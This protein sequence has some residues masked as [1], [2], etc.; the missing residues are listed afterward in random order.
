MAEL[1]AALGGTPVVPAGTVQPYPHVTDEDREA[2]QAA[3]ADGDLTKSRTEQS[4]GLAREFAEYLGVRHVV[5]TNSGT[6]AL[7]LAVAG[8]GIEP[9]DEVICPAFTY[10][11]TAAAVLHHN[12]IP[13]FVDVEPGTWTLDPAKLEAAIT[14]RTRAVIPVHIHGMPADL[15]PIL[16]IAE[17]HGLQVIEDCAQSHGA[18]YKGKLCGAIGH[19]AGFSLQATKLLTTGS[20]GGLFAT[21]DDLICERA[22]LLQYLGELVVPGRERLDQEYNAF[23]LGWMYRGD[24]LGQA[25][26]RSQLRRLD[27]NNAERIRNCEHLTR[28]LAGLPGVSTPMLPPDRKMVYYSYTVRFHPEELGLDVPAPR[29]RDCIERA[30][31]AEGVPCGRWQTMPV[32]SQRI[33]QDK[34]GYGK[35]C[36]W[37]CPHAGP[38]EYDPKGYPVTQSFIDTQMYVLGIWGPNGPDLMDRFADAFEKLLAQ[39]EAVLRLA[40]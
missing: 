1:P 28:R 12:G 32:P 29:F 24:V 6:S 27:Q 19:A 23:G 36:P 34:V 20:E 10:W 26:A 39:P 5:P 4:Q 18:L 16:A 17:R 13:V 38:V 40:E 25:F 9:G 3:L 15:D 14:E 8:I 7:H 30:L 33:F 22:S 37:C 35:G 11:A 21:N 31:N 2:V